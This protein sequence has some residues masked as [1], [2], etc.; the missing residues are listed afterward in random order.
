MKTTLMKRSLIFMMLNR[1][2]FRR[3]Y[4]LYMDYIDIHSHRYLA[5]YHL[6]ENKTLTWQ[7][8]KTVPNMPVKH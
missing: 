2:D 1:F 8:D 5:K 6:I 7:E 3:H 4:F